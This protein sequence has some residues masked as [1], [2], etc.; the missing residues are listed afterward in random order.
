MSAA[1]ESQRRATQRSATPMVKDPLCRKTVAPRQRGRQP[2]RAASLPIPGLSPSLSLSL[3][4]SPFC[5]HLCRPPG[6]HATRQPRSAP[7]ALSLPLSS[8]CFSS[9]RACRQAQKEPAGLRHTHGARAAALMFRLL[10]RRAR[11]ARRRCSR[12]SSPSYTHGEGC[13]GNAARAR[14]HPPPLPL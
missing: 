10:A 11:T 5:L 2:I 14:A 9:P 8:L 12:P 1:V 4:L 6:R 13:N 7:R 3:S